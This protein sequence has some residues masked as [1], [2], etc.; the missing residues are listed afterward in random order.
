MPL[1]EYHCEECDHVFEKM[2]PFSQADSS[3]ECPHCHH[4]ITRRKISTFATRIASTGASSSS[5]GSSCGSG[6][7]R[8][9]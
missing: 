3:P 9:T 6:G 7:G 8:F 4:D 1:Y 5:S 2:M